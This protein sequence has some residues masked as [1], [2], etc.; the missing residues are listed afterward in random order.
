MLSRTEL[1][2]RAVISGADGNPAALNLFSGAGGWEVGASSLGLHFLGIDKN[3]NALATARAAG[4]QVVRR[5]IEKLNPKPFSW[6]RGMC[7]SPPC[8]GF[9][10]SGW[11]NGRRDLD[12]ILAMI[13]DIR[14]GYRSPDEAIA[15]V[16]TNA[17]DWRSRLVLEP[18]RWVLT[19][20]YE[21]TAWEQVPSLLPVWQAC[22][23][24]LAGRGYHVWTGVLDAERYGVPQTRRRAV[25]GASKAKEVGEPT[26][27][28]SRFYLRDRTRR[29]EGLPGAVSMRVA[30]GWDTTERIVL[31]TSQRTSTPGRARI[32][33]ELDEPAATITGKSGNWTRFEDLGPKAIG[34]RVSVAEA[35]MLQTFPMDYPWQ[36]NSA[37][38]FQLVGNAIPPLLAQ[39]VLE[40]V[41]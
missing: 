41:I 16:A 33:R 26:P 6:Y 40:Q 29:D 22:A 35:G 3:V 12:L 28:H 30:L 8:Q 38:Q 11:G 23:G 15:Y 31:R 24:V 19:N 9:S 21:W 13:R 10:A 39:R 36:G 4:F 34:P 37:E 20:D 18:L 7:A 27:T 1:S 14:T 17:A 5:H 32:F 25:L 2:P